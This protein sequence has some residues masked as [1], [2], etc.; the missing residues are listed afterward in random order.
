MKNNIIYTLR[1]DFST[2]QES[3]VFRDRKKAVKEWCKKKG[4]SDIYV[5]SKGK[6]DNLSIVPGEVIVERK[7]K[8][9][10]R[11]FKY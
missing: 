11:D 7:S 9:C 3:E 1:A 2:A 4:K 5:D 8:V 10:K 6:K